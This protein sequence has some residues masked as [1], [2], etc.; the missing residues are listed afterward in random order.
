MLGKEIYE[1]TGKEIGRRVL[2][3]QGGG[4]RMETSF[5]EVG[6]LLG[7]EIDNSGTFTGVMRPDGTLFGEGQGIAMSKEG[8]GITW[9]GQ[10]VGRMGQN[11]TAS[12]RGA[13]YFQTASPKF[14]QLNGIV[15]VYE[16]EIAADGTHKGK[17]WE[18]K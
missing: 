5:R 10:G 12:H 7:V 14:A 8:D 13:F 18:W 15:G 1:A 4:P 11:G 6:K 9:V 17:F 16:Y 3:S 2:P